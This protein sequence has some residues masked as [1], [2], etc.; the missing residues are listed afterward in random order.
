M[1]HGLN[2][3]QR[4]AVGTLRG[5]LLVL[6]GAG[7]GKTR[8][9]TY[10]IA[11]LIRRG[12]PADR[13][14]AVTFTNKAA[15][16]MQ[17]RAA[18][19]LGK[20]LPKRPEISTFHS[21]CVRILRRHANRLGY[22]E[23]F[24]IYDRG[25]Q[26][27][28]ARTALREISVP[29][30]VL[31]PGDLLYLISRWKSLGAGP[32]QAASQAASDREHLAASAFRRYQNALKAAGAVDFDDLLLCTEELL[33]RFADVRQAEAGRFDHLLVDEYQDTS[34]VQY[35]IVRHLA[36]GHRNLCVVGDDD[37]S[38]YAWRGAEVA[39]ILR[40]K[41]DWPE[42]KVVR[43]EDNYRSTEAILRWPTA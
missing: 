29:D 2:P 28:V 35:R 22:P 25:D 4:E 9:V 7:T 17:Q 27:S 36:G 12:T 26:E 18:D 6:A 5:P 3:P 39:H 23:R 15:K 34:G 33:S 10:R 31:R 32:E 42:A 11:E 37:Q 16:E 40:F 41:T 13:I 8:V 19:L 21:L 20:R 24:A 14:L 1:A 43:L 30:G 38:I